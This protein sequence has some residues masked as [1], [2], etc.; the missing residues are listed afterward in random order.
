ML[1]SVKRLLYVEENGST[2]TRVIHVVEDPLETTAKL[3]SAVVLSQETVLEV[4]EMTI[5]LGE[6]L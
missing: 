1:D 2:V 4:R 3:M 5:G 6:F